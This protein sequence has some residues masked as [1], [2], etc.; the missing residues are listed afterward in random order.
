[1]GTD[2][3]MY[4]EVRRNKQWAKVGKVF[5][6]TYYLADRPET[7]WNTPL[8]DHPYDDRNYDLFAIL[9]DVRNG[10]GFAGCRTSKGFNP[11]AEP[12]G[13]PDDITP[14]VA[15]MLDDWGYGYSWFTLKE[16]KDYDWNQTAIHVG[17]LTEEQYKEM[18][19]TG[20]HPKS[21]CGGCSGRDIVTVDS[22]T[23]DKILNKT[24]DRNLN[25][26]YYV[27]TEFPAQTYKDCCWTFVEKTI[28]ALEALV[29]EDGTD[30]DV[31]ILFCFDC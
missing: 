26:R 1:M 12:K 4:A 19:E 30:E 22:S 21:W 10:H 18:K 14:E 8:T 29:P 17:V 7:E 16:L 24:M 13:L 5:K 9:A 3:T 25:I 27:Q 2:I 31:R 28:P 15:E 6:N 20:E 11:I 23:M